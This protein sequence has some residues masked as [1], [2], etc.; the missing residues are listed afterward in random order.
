MFVDKNTKHIILFCLIKTDAAGENFQACWCHSWPRGAVSPRLSL[1]FPTG[2][3][4]LSTHRERGYTSALTLCSRNRPFFH[5]VRY[6]T[7]LPFIFNVIS[8]VLLGLL[9]N[10]CLCGRFIA[11]EGHLL[12][13]LPAVE[14]TYLGSKERLNQI[15][16]MFSK[17]TMCQSEGHAGSNS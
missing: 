3:K 6:L 5:R 7:G 11:S 13:G 17:S 15:E 10:A 9:Q 2:G 14:W 8:P 12:K 16:K 1:M 4:G